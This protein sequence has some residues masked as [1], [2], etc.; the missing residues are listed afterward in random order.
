APSGRCRGPAPGDWL[1]A[2]SDALLTGQA[3]ALP[4]H[5]V[6]GR[7]LPQ[8]RRVLFPAP[9]GKER[10]AGWSAGGGRGHHGLR[11]WG[12]G[13][14]ADAERIDEG[15]CIISETRHR[16][17]SHKGSCQASCEEGDRMIAVRSRPA[18]ENVHRLMLT[19]SGI[20]AVA[21]PRICSRIDR[22]RDRTIRQ[23]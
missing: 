23:W 17:K 2:A 19:Y 7:A 10:R 6:P 15:E 1:W 5:V 21:A 22:L 8:P 20:P 13:G 4:G 14:Q 11:G 18:G 9:G 3:L 16:I 12:V